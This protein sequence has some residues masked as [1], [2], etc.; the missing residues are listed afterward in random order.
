MTQ[1]KVLLVA[2]IA[3]IAGTAAVTTLPS[4]PAMA[5]AAYAEGDMVLGS[6]DAPVTI[7]EYASMT[8]PHCATFHVETFKDFK[9]KYIESG[10]VR[11]I[12]REFPFDQFALQGSMLARCSGA[13]RYFTMLDLLF[14]QQNKWAKSENPTQALGQIARF[15][16]MSQETFDRCIGNETLMNQILKTRMTAHQEQGVGS[17]P[18]FIVNDDKYTGAMTLAE[19]DDILAKYLN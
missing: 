6:A 8:C 1:L 7:I 16:G 18:T 3:V 4:R 17:T 10:K 11:F 13:D 5:Q 12:F 9:A 19:W 15:S 14:R 2:M